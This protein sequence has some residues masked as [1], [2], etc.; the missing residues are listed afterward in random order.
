[1]KHKASGRVLIVISVIFALIS[2]TAYGQDNEK[3]QKQQTAFTANIM[4]HAVAMPFNK[5]GRNFSNPGLA[6]GISKPL[7]KKKRWRYTPTLGY[8]R[9]AAMGDGFMF[10]NIMQ[11]RMLKKL[12]VR[13]VAGIGLGYMMSF[14]PRKVWEINNGVWEEKTGKPSHTIS[15]PIMAGLESKAMPISGRDFRFFANY[16]FSLQLFYSPSLPV[17]PNTFFNFGIYTP[18]K[19]KA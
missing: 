15:I 18:L 4:F 12:P 19:K 2:R 7:G 6:V 16:M 14:H 8:Y 10:N 13:P 9:D 11:L 3:D 17:F 1:M 5:M